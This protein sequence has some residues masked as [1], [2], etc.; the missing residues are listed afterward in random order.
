MD[1]LATTFGRRV[2]LLR[3]Q[4]GL[5]QE[6]LGRRTELDHKYIGNIERGERTPSFEGMA[7]LAQALGVEVYEL[8]LPDRLSVRLLQQE[9]GGIITDLGQIERPDLERFFRDVLAA[10]TRLGDRK[11]PAG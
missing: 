11:N 2:R 8:F 5:T 7:R 4:R 6:E 10:T 1:G 9:L 3:K